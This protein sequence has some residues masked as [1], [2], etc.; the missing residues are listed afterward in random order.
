MNAIRLWIAAILLGCTATSLVAAEPNIPKTDEAKQ[1]ELAIVHGP[2]LQQPRD[3]SMTVLWFT[4]HPCTSWVEYGTDE[5]L[6][7]RAMSAHHGLIDTND[8]RH[9]V[10]ISGLTP[11]KTYRYR[12]VSREIISEEAYRPVK[13][14]KTVASETFSFTTC[15]AAKKDFSFWVTSDIHGSSD[16]LQSLFKA[17]DWRGVDLVF[18][19]GDMLSAMTQE[20]EVFRGYFDVCVKTFAQTTPMVHVRGNHETRGPAARRLADYALTSEGRF[21]YSFN[22]G[23]VHFIVLDSGEDKLDS[24]KEY[25]GLAAFEP[26]VRTQT[27]WLARDLKA[28]ASRTATYRVAVFHMPP[29]DDPEWRGGIRVRELWEPLLNEGGVDLVLCGH[30]HATKH[31]APTEGKNRFELLTGSNHAMIRADVTPKQL[32]VVV[33]EVDGR[34]SASVKI[35]PRELRTALQPV[36]PKTP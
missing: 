12:V 32:S 11:G 23:G 16:L 1:V 29:S 22:H 10:E 30:T 33:T 36:P 27:D 8:T 34:S 25:S 3:I 19:N 6:S 2:C 15:N 17:T 18:L 9:A 13:Y 21:Y 4:N 7:S 26:Y 5:E 31:T 24:H 20:R 14:G 35:V 28:E